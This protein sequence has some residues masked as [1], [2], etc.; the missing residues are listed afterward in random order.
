MKKSYKSRIGALMSQSEV[1]VFILKLV[2]GGISAF[3]GII[4]WS[5]TKDSAWMNIIAGIVFYYIS[6]VYELITSLGFVIPGNVLLFGVPIYTLI[7]TVLPYV[8]FIAA[9][10]IILMKKR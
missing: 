10:C 6:L 7:A 4:L 3:L 9:F 2:L 5:K 8:F 1:F